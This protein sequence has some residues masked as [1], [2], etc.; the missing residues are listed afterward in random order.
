MQEHPGDDPIEEGEKNPAQAQIEAASR[1]A[2]QARD[3]MAN[4]SDD[5]HKEADALAERARLARRQLQRQF[6]D[7]N[8]QAFAKEGDSHRGLGYGLA[9]GYGF[10][11]ATILGAGIGWLI[12]RAA[13]TTMWL[14][15]C[16][17]AGF[18]LGLYFVIL[19]TQR[20]E[21]K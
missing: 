17:I 7:K 5:M 6:P 19:T 14:G 16:G 18:A 10:M 11:G 12:D 1:A 9:A 20:A 21:K 13:G 8:S 15:I 3:K 4:V 2:Q